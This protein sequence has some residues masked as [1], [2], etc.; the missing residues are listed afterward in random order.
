MR[1][2]DL[3]LA[4]RR[5]RHVELEVDQIQLEVQ[6]L[7]V[8][9]GRLGSGRLAVSLQGGFVSLGKRSLGLKLL[10]QEA[11]DRYLDS[12]RPDPGPGIEELGFG[13][14][15]PGLDPRLEHLDRFDRDLLTGIGPCD[16]T[17][18]RGRTHLLAGATM[19]G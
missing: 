1:G 17:G 9:S 19:L 11:V 3:R 16:E 2:R 15:V 4:S 8:G 5:G 14:H 6:V 7:R 13:R 12:R 18:S 10:E